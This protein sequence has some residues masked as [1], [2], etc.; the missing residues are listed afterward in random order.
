MSPLPDVATVD[1]FELGQMVRE[2][3]KST[4]FGAKRNVYAAFA[5]RRN[6]G[7]QAV[8]RSVSS[9]EFLTDFVHDIDRQ[10]AI[11][12]R[13]QPLQAVLILA[14]WSNFGPDDAI[15]FA[16]RLIR[17]EISVQHLE[18]EERAARLSGDHVVGASPAD[19]RKFH[20][21]RIAEHVRSEYGPDWTLTW[22][23]RGWSP[24]GFKSSR[25]PG[26]LRAFSSV[27]GLQLGFVS[28]VDP[29]HLVVSVEIRLDD[30]SR[31]Q[32]VALSNL[33]T[34]IGYAAIGYYVA[35]FASSAMTVEIMEEAL[36]K[37]GA[38][39]K[40]AIERIRIFLYD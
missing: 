23:A 8:Q 32:Y 13:S 30:P 24:I 27:P 34:L 26:P 18:A 31:Q 21:G 12:L 19:R 35:C 17:K 20:A 37:I 4:R 2:E 36:R 33:F 15:K 22:A 29:L 28:E 40:T 16:R 38:H 25:L 3:L 39:D 6:V 11:E 1:W 5:A 14:K 10:L 9:A 7:I